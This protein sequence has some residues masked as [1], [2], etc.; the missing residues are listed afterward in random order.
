[1]KIKATQEMQKKK[2]PQ[3]DVSIL[4]R[5]IIKLKTKHGIYT[6]KERC[7]LFK[8]NAF[9]S[10][11]LNIHKERIIN[12]LNKNIEFS[13]HVKREMGTTSFFDLASSVSSSTDVDKSLEKIIFCCDFVARFA[14]L[15]VNTKEVE[16]K[17][18]FKLYSKVMPEG[19]SDDLIA[20][21]FSVMKKHGLI[22]GGKWTTEKVTKKTPKTTKKKTLPL[23]AASFTVDVIKCAFY[24]P[25][26]YLIE[27]QDGRTIWQVYDN[28][29]FKRNKNQKD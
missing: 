18:L 17:E 6:A 5:E 27:Q 1:M 26:V 25:M 22:L 28:P 19:I 10:H 29:P 23:I 12:D 7:D 16:T 24:L 20:D 14:Q 15:G 11:T 21:A 4:K 3:S 8:Q 13:N 9:N 2:P